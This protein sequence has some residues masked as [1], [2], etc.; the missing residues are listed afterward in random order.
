MLQERQVTS[1]LILRRNSLNTYLKKFDIKKS[2]HI[3]MK[4]QSEAD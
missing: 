2:A 3:Y 4:F 1:Y